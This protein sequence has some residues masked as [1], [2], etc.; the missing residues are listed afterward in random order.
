MSDEILEEELQVLESIYPTELTKLSDRELQIDVEPEDLVE[1]DDVR[2]TLT[3]AYP[4]SYPEVLPDL[5]IEPHEACLE[6]SDV[7][8]LT[9]QMKSAGEENLGMAMTFTLVS[10]L[11]EQLSVLAKAKVEKRKQEEKEKERLALEEEAARTRGTPVTVASFKSWKARFDKE[12]SVAKSREE[13][14]RTKGMTPKEREEYKKITTRLSG[15]QLFERNKHLATAEDSLVEEGTESVDISQYERQQT[16]D[17]E[18]YESHLEFSD[19]D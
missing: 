2:V 10:H 15:R 4:E 6:E 14:E 12:L 9:S 11:R 7:E 3:V 18:E 5:S 17:E 1:G 16:I 8:S 13:E 19:S